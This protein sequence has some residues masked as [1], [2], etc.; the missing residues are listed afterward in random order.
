MITTLK[1]KFVSSDKIKRKGS[2][3]IK[4]NALK[5]TRTEYVSGKYPNSVGGRRRLDIGRVFDRADSN[6]MFDVELKSGLNNGDRCS[7]R[8]LNYTSFLTASVGLIYSASQLESLKVDWR[9]DDQPI[10]SL[11]KLKTKPEVDL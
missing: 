4:L 9:L 10:T 2:E 7:R 5:S 8:L 3:A 1:E 6:V 11:P